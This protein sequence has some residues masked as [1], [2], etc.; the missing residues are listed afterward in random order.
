MSDARD[1]AVNPETAQQ[2]EIS[3]SYYSVVSQLVSY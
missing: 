2:A 3:I 1:D